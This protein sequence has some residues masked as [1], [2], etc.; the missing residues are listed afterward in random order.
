LITA[1]GAGIGKEEQDFNI[2]KVR[3][4]KIIIMTNVFL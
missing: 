3:Y 2:D 4:H 1:I